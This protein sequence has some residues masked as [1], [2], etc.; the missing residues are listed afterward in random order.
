MKK[1][2]FLLMLTALITFSCE[3]DPLHVETEIKFVEAESGFA[4]ISTSSG[5][6]SRSG[7]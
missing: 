5:A 6:A 1:V 2:L 7:D 4:T 3:E